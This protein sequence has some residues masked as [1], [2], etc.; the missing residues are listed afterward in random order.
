MTNSLKCFNRL[1]I[2]QHCINSIYWPSAGFHWGTAV[3]L[4]SFLSPSLPG[5]IC[6][7][8]DHTASCNNIRINGQFPGQYEPWLTS[9]TLDFEVMII[10]KGRVK[11]T[12]PFSAL[13]LLVWR[14][15]GHPAWKKLGVGLLVA[16]IWLELCTSYSS[17]CHHHF[18]HPWL[19]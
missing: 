15:E 11:F 6:P 8:L 3:H 18:H 2:T 10:C 12:F 14:Q 7:L 4:L 16:T 19:Q 5:S 1:K 17:S 9:C 13:T